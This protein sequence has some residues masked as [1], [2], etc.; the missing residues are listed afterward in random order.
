MPTPETILYDVQ[1]KANTQSADASV[2]SLGQK[3]E[4]VGKNSKVAITG[5]ASGLSQTI[6][7]ADGALKSLATKS[8]R[9]AITADA[10]GLSSAVVTAEGSLKGLGSAAGA[11]AKGLGDAFRSTQHEVEKLSDDIDKAGSHSSALGKL[12]SAL[13]GGGEHGGEGGGGGSIA[14]AVLGSAVGAGAAEAAIKGFEF[15]AEK[16]GEAHAATEQVTVALAKA[17]LTGEAASKELERIGES[18]SKIGDDFALPGNEV[19]QLMG[20]ITGFSGLTGGALDHLTEISIG[21]SK[22]LGLSAEGVA[23]LIAKSA[24]PESVATLKR[25][26]IQFDA[27]ATAAEKMAVIEK[28]LGPAIQGAKDANNDAFGSFE[29]VK[30]KL[31]ETVVELGTKLFAALGPAITALSGVISDL[32]PIVG[33]VI[34]VLSFLLKVGIQISL[35]PL[36]AAK[37]FIGWL[38]TLQPVKD[39]IAAVG[40]AI[41]STKEFISGLIDTVKNAGASLLA[42][43]GINIKDTDATK[44]SE[45]A[46]ESKK[47]AEEAA[48]TTV[49]KMSD[50]LDEQTA[51]YDANIKSTKDGIDTDVARGKLLEAQVRN[52]ALPKIVRDQAAEA[53][54]LFKADIKSKQSIIEQDAKDQADLLGTTEKTK[55]KVHDDAFQS[56]IKKLAAEQ[57]DRE[58]RTLVFESQLQAKVLDE[59]QKGLRATAELTK[60]EE[61]IIAEHKLADRIQNQLEINQRI[62]KLDAAGNLTALKIALKPDEQTALKEQLSSLGQSISSEQLNIIKM[63]PV[64]ADAAV[65]NVHR[66]AVELQKQ[67]EAL[68]IGNIADDQARET[69]ALEAKQA[70]ENSYLNALKSMG[71][72]L[73]QQELDIEKE[74][75]IKH[76]NELLELKKKYAEKAND[77]GAKIIE[78]GFNAILTKQKQVSAAEYNI[79][80]S[81]F[82]KEQAAL[83]ASLARGELSQQDYNNKVQ[84]LNQ[85]KSDFEKANSNSVADIAVKAYKAMAGAALDAASASMA[86]AAANLIAADMTLGPIAGPILAALAVGVIKGLTSE[87]KS[88]VGF[89]NGGIII[90][91]NTDTPE[92]VSPAKEFSQFATQLVTQTVK[93]TQQA[94]GNSSPGSPGRSRGTIRHKIEFSP[95]TASGR[96]LETT[97]IKEGL[98]KKTELLI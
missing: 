82:D 93:Q 62:G 71:V 9:V 23:R 17:G 43:I 4:A 73:T 33:P 19:K 76:Q 96:D 31:T 91:E 68:A 26:G 6:A 36:N 18:A 5:D 13:S 84:L 24:D 89:A 65:E 25:L 83:R 74:L 48:I 60:D 67:L 16:A 8:S 98:A 38:N 35:F 27:N 61:R 54:R 92:I 72:Q 58:N 14:G 12:K 37:A 55:A 39:A 3:L 56:E 53:L 81:G 88:L 51:A 90:N 69:A 21:A 32:L 97:T 85:Q 41:Q 44:A 2:A 30:N 11:Q 87:V 63:Q 86:T 45:A 70:E 15:L 42:L 22:A 52:A 7:S 29:K 66:S 94:M 49:K 79:K 95:L 1:V 28:K 80:I 40:N 75:N 50:A 78:A 57:K 10:S 34:D 47:A 64:I 46:I 59:F 20:T 77:A